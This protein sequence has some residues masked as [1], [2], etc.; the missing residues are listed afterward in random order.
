MSNSEE[1]MKQITIQTGT[2]M[3]ITTKKIPTWG[4]LSGV[5]LLAL[6]QALGQTLPLE[7]RQDKTLYNYQ[8]A[9]GVPPL[10]RT[11]ARQPPL[12]RGRRA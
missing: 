12:R 3:K 4:V 11:V 5:L 6:G 1:Q 7:I 2:Q 8:S 9:K 10:G